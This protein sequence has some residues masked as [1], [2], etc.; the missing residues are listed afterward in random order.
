[1]KTLTINTNLDNVQVTV[2]MPWHRPIDIVAI[3][4]LMDHGKLF[5]ITISSCLSYT[6]GITTLHVNFHSQTGSYV[7]C[8]LS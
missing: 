3:R 6:R 1:M 7:A 2:A 5:M 4:G 8:H